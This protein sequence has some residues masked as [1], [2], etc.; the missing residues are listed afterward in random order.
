MRLILAI[1]ILAQVFAMSRAMAQTVTNKMPSGILHD[2]FDGNL[3][4]VWSPYLGV[5]AMAPIQSIG[6]ISADSGNG[7]E[8]FDLSAPATLQTQIGVYVSAF[9]NPWHL[10]FAV[11]Y[12]FTKLSTELGSAQFHNAGVEFMPF[13]QIGNHRLG[14]GINQVV[15]A[16][17]NASDMVEGGK[18]DLGHP[19]G[20]AVEYG[21]NLRALSSWINLR[22]QSTSF[23]VT[24]SDQPALES[25]IID[26]SVGA[27]ISFQFL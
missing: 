19:M 9:D 23:M 13:Y 7:V 25:K 4:D 22:Y 8:S 5:G 16:S 14:A 10:R 11:G 24:E 21:Y 17:I 18:Y 27:S 26:Q 6:T 3:G 12:G 1:A 2:V 20:Y 15:Y